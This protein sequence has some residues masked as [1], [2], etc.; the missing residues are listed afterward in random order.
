MIEKDPASYTLLTYGWVMLLAWWG[1]IASYL[2][3]IRG[4]IIHRFSLVEFIGEMV[5]SGFVGVLTF[6]LCESSGFSGT[7]TA[8]FVG[9]SGHMG[10]RAIF[11]M[12]KFAQ[13]QLDKV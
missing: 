12:E 7:L 6:Y 3:K 2:R 9:I 5:I 11:A 13:R 1:G 4:G 8:A 10:S